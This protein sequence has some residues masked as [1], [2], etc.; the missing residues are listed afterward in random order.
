MSSLVRATGVRRP[1]ELFLPG[2]ALGAMLVWFFFLLPLWAPTSPSSFD[3]YNVL[4]NFSSVGLLALGIGLTMVIRELDLSAVGI[5]S[6]AGIV[7]IKA[8]E[9]H[10]VLG[11]LAAVGVGALFG[12]VQ[13]GVIAKLR[14]SSLPVTLGGLITLTGLTEVLTN[15]KNVS[16]SNPS[17]GLWLDQVVLRT[18]S[19]RSLIAL[20]VFA[21]FALTMLITRVG[22]DVRAVGGEREAS[23]AAG[24]PVDRLIVATF[25]VS[26]AVSALGGSMLAY[27][28]ASAAADAN[29]AP[30][31]VAVTAALLGAVSL[32]GARGTV[33]GILAGSLALSLLEQGFVLLGTQAYA[34]QIVLGIL[35]TVVAIA[36][37]PG[38]HRLVTLT[39]AH[40]HSFGQ[41]GNASTAGT[42]PFAGRDA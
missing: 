36:D 35:L 13:G 26:G 30:L 23:R 4:Q 8:G 11:V 22:R 31:I 3:V 25:A 29:L 32:N 17:A 9:S 16:Y 37:A 39:S 10:P 14:L 33:L 2:T 5:F 21:L 7:A 20:G 40:L 6:V 42:T 28:T 34:S 24:V 19:P 15:G 18:V 41:G 12:A 38:L 1:A 27:S